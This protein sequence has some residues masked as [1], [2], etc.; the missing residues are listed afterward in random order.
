MDKKAKK[1]K[2]SIAVEMVDTGK[3][4]RNYDYRIQRFTRFGKE[5]K[6]TPKANV[7]INE[8]G[9]KTEFFVET[10]NVVVGIG[11]HHSADLIMT[12]EAWKALN[13]GEKVHITTTEEFKKKFGG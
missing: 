12:V 7:S 4:T 10:V 11:E 1:Q 8:P 2:D 9:F 13:N 5:I 3:V 6:I